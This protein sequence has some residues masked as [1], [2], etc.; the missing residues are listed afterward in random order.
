M[1]TKQKRAQIEN[2]FLFQIAGMIGYLNRSYY[3]F[4]KEYSQVS[5]HIWSAILHLTQAKKV[6]KQVQADRK[7]KEEK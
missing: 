3:Q 2:W 5:H 7:K 4:N 1:I 6:I